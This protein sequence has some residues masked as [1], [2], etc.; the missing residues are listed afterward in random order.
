[1]IRRSIVLGFVLCGLSSSQL[2]AHFIWLLPAKAEGQGQPQLQLCFCE[3]ARPGEAELIN[4]VAGSKAWVCFSGCPVA[5]ELELEKRG[6]GDTACLVA[7]APTQSVYRSEA[8][9]D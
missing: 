3:E 4:K 9:C 5:Q 8:L 2:W 7:P 6:E 1:M